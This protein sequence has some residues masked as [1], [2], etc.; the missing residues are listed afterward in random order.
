MQRLIAVS[1]NRQRSTGAQERLQCK[2]H[3]GTVPH[4]ASGGAKQLGQTLP[5][6]ILWCRNTYPAT[7]TQLLNRVAIARR[8]RDRAVTATRRMRITDPPQG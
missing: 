8:N 3:V 7:G 1:R 5:T 4:F 6:L 2:R